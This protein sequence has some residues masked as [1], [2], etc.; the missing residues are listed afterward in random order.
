MSTNQSQISSVKNYLEHQYY[1]NNSPPH[2]TYGAH[3]NYIDLADRDFYKVHECH[4]NR[5]WKG[6][7]MLSIM[8][9]VIHNSWVHS[10]SQHGLDFLT[11]RKNLALELAQFNQSE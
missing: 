5:N 4:P 1:T 7:M 2:Q 11:F 3:F 8:R 10:I 9:I 6:K